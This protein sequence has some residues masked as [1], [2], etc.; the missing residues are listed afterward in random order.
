[1]IKGK[2]VFSQLLSLLGPFI[3]LRISKKY[4]G[5]KYVKHFTCWNQF[6]VLMFGKSHYNI[7]NEL[8]GSNEPTLL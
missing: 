4:D 3:F 7:V 8:K 2:N 5:N 1:M 6:A